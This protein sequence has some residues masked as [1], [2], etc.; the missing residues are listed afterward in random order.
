MYHSFAGSNHYPG[1]SGNG[2]GVLAEAGLQDSELTIGGNLN[3]FKRVKGKEERGWTGKSTLGN[4]AR[5]RDERRVEGE[6]SRRAGRN[7]LTSS[8]LR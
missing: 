3:Y 5:C 1:R 8:V 2:C 4:G 6:R 7:Y